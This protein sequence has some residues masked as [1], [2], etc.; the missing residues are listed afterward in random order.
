MTRWIQPLSSFRGGSMTLFVLVLAASIGGLSPAL[1]LTAPAAPTGDDKGTAEIT[2]TIVKMAPQAVLAGQLESD[3]N[4]E[5]IGFYASL[6]SPDL[7]QINVKID[8]SQRGAFQIKQLPA[9]KWTL[10]ISST[11]EIPKSIQETVELK[12]GEVTR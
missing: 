4:S 1:A 3:A 10:M 5:G 9:G 12:E 8:G 7:Q 6:L 11:G 2:G